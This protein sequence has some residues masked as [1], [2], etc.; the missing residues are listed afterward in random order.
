MAL[1]ENIR[2]FVR[3]YELGSMSAAARDQRVSPAVASSRI[4]ALE[5]HLKVRLFQRTTRSLRPTEHGE[6]FYDGAR[7]VVEAVEAAEGRVAAITGSPR[8]LLSVSAPLR[9]GRR[10]LAPIVPSFMDDYPGLTMRLRLTDRG[11]ELT[12]E[13]LDVAIILGTPEDSNLKI[14]KICDCRRVLVAAPSYVAERGMPRDGEALVRDG[15]ECLIL[16][17]P[18]ATEFRWLLRTP[19]GPRRFGVTGRLDCDDGATLMD[20]ALMGRGIILKPLWEVAEA[21]AEGTLVQVAHETPPE[22]IQLAC[23]YAHRR[24]QDPKRRLFMDWVA[25]RLRDL[26]AKAEARAPQEPR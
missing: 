12:A 18:G 19:E 5:E 23:L 9:L 8:G 11:V 6:A 22:P 3:V 10:L 2:L 24:L 13:G 20:W 15:H 17:Y 14:R 21:M 16:R 7:E 4:A 25:P 1:L 26:V